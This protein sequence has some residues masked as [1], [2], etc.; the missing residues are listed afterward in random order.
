MNR[1]MQLSDFDKPE[2]PTH[3]ESYGFVA[4]IALCLL[5]DVLLVAAYFGY[6]AV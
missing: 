4:A 6:R 5:F 2:R 1:H 3:L